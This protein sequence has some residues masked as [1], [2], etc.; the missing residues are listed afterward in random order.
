M[1]PHLYRY[2]QKKCRR[3]AFLSHSNPRMCQE[4]HTILAEALEDITMLLSS[5]FKD[6]ESPLVKKNDMKRGASA[7]LKTRLLVDNKCL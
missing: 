4:Y 5:Q 3:F 2:P 7:K 6:N 1:D